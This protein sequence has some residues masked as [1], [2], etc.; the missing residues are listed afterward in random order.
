MLNASIICVK[1]FHSFIMVKQTNFKHCFYYNTAA[2]MPQELFNCRLA[3]LP[4]W[5]ELPSAPPDFL[6]SK[7]KCKKGR[8]TIDGSPL[9]EYNRSRKKCDGIKALRYERVSCAFFLFLPPP[10]TDNDRMGDLGLWKNWNSFTKERPRRFSA[11]TTRTFISWI[12]RTT[13]PP[14]TAPKRAPSAAK[15]S[16]TTASPTT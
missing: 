11:P 6:P 16:S 10:D 13:Q 15:A 14:A 2:N 1:S 7:T 5:T 12:I 8:K 4:Y 9:P 3:F